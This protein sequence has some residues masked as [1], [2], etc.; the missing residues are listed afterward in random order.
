MDVYGTVLA[1]S[2]IFFFFFFLLLL[3][4][5]LESGKMNNKGMVIRYLNNWCIFS[6]SCC[7]DKYPE[8]L[9]AEWDRWDE[10]NSSENDRPGMLKVITVR[11]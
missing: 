8:H 3:L 10:E 7:Q 11:L 1:M 5:L 9:L 4:L 6:V 2:L